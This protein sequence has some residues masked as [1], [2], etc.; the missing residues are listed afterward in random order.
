LF[1]ARRHFLIAVI[2]ALLGGAAY[3]AIDLHRSGREQVLRQYNALQLLLAKEAAHEAVLYLKEASDYLEGLARLDSVRRSR[4][5]DIRKDLESYRGSPG[6]FQGAA[7]SVVNTQGVAAFSTA[8][9]M[10]G[11]DGSA[12]EFFQWAK[13]KRN[14]GK[15]YISSWARETTAPNGIA[16]G[17]FLL[18]T[19]LYHSDRDST[20]GR[21]VK[22]R[23]GVLLLTVDL[24]GFLTGHLAALG[25]ASGLDRI[26]IM[27]RDGTIL[28]QSEHPEMA[29]L[30]IFRAGPQ[31]AQCHV[32]FDYARTM[33]VGGSGAAE[34]QLKQQPKKLAAFVPV[35]VAN[36][37]WVLVVNTPYD[38]VTA[39]V[40]REFRRTL[41][42]IGTVVLALCLASL[43]VYRANVLR[44]R[45]REEAR[46]WRERLELEE[47]IRR[48][49]ERFRTLFEQSPDGILMVDP[50]TM[51]PIEFSEA[52][53]RQLGY[54][55]EEFA[56]MPV[57][58]HEG[59][60]SP[61]AARA[62]IKRLLAQGSARF[63][64]E[65]RTKE[66]ARCNVEVIAQTLKLENRTVLLCIH[67]DITERKRAE[68]ALARRSTQLE[69]LHEVSLRI[70]AETD[71]GALLRTIT[72][73]ALR[74]FRGTAGGLL[75]CR[76]EPQALE[77]VVSVGGDPALVGTC[78]KKGE[79]L[80]G[81][82]WETGSPLVL[83]HHP[84]RNGQVIAPGKWPCAS[85]IA[86]PLRWGED[87][88]GVLQL[89]SDTPG[90]WSRED[91][92]L[93]EL[94]ATQAAIAVKN[95]ALL[96]Q[97]RRDDTTKTTLLHD[98]NHRVKNNLARLL[99][100]VRLEAE[101]SAPG[102]P[103]CQGAFRDLE[104]RLRGMETV[105]TM[106]STSQWHPLPLRELVTQI[107]SGALSGSRLHEQIQV[108]V[109]APG[110]PLWVVP[111]QA[112]ALAL[113]LSELTS[114][115]VKH[116]FRHRQEGRLEVHLRVENGSAGRPLVRLQ[117]SDD[118][119]GWPE[120]V[121][122]GQSDQV[123]LR[124]IRS[125]VRSPLRGELNLRNEQGAV[126][127]LVFRLAL[128]K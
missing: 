112:T 30:N 39:F 4:W 75:L 10:Q 88:L 34:Y 65:Q 52:A 111:E 126:A 46:Q 3:L 38:E 113:I 16:P 119:P 69:A 100:I 66:G 109:L 1:V 51:L 12:A 92:A 6:A 110:D 17:S 36:A 95:A 14:E 27:D 19:P 125:S 45:A 74:L 81:K 9:D 106:L 90:F 84:R 35:Q 73:Q 23:S 15:V 44:L 37:S 24:Q 41:L 70:A 62:R 11:W 56:R 47:K 58:D 80:A 89:G 116:A 97:V 102:E 124:L 122:N 96:D 53:H 32:S 118:G 121:L 108:S 104:N 103:G 63:E 48:A 72:T 99:E 105:H 31:C 85:A 33:L 128:A 86:A 13:D 22:T 83:G 76:R 50:E 61:E 78:V 55:R 79:E 43:M 77:W 82:S 71:T 68:E 8:G 59:G 91:A 57:G 127:E 26:W 115:S 18:A 54:S 67:H 101:R 7:I 40:G 42:L 94:I 60:G 49:E 123:G 64:I 28:M 29:R 20:S 107:V 114:N 2:L 93:L 87:F 120:P 98:V 21:T 25:P 117:Y 5:E